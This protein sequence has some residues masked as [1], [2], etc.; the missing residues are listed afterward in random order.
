[1]KN[2][3]FAI[4]LYSLIVEAKKYPQNADNCTLKVF[5]LMVRKILYEKL[6]LTAAQT[7]FFCT[8]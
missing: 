5:N 2:E 1:M 3:P 4:F 7:P 6:Q 8:F